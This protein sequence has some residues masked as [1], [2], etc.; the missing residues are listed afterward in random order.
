MCF[1]LYHELNFLDQHFFVFLKFKFQLL[2]EEKLKK[3]QRAYNYLAILMCNI[4]FY[5]I[6][7]F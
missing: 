1:A 3:I 2:A 5:F 6:F 7:Y 4:D